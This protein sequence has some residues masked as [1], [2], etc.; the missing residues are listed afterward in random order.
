MINPGIICS[1]QHLD[2]GPWI[3]LPYWKNGLTLQTK[4]GVHEDGTS[5]I[6]ESKNLSPWTGVKC[7]VKVAQSCPTLCYPRDYT[8]HGF[9]QA[10]I[11]E[12]VAF[13]FSRV[14]F[15]PRDWI[16]VSHI[17][18][19]FFT[20]WATREA[21]EYWSGEPIPSPADLTNPGIKPGS[22]A[23]QADSL[24]TELWGKLLWAVC[25]YLMNCELP[26]MRKRATSYISFYFIK[27]DFYMTYT[28]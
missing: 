17:A 6:L 16:Q 20:S 19:W 12:W 10:R 7:E 21:Q 1:F 8:V 3:P 15:Q 22:P 9:L 2:F 11:L 26:Y 4:A 23:S 5:S 24:P 18:G 14:P 25:V 27:Y 28:N 13:P